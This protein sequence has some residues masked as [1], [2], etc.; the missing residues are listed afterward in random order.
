[1]P[2]VSPAAN[3]ETICEE[4]F[5]DP[6]PFLQ[7]FAPFTYHFPMD[8]LIAAMKYQ[9]RPQLSKLLAKLMI[10]SLA[11]SQQQ[12]PELFIPIPMHPS[13]QRLR[14]YNQAH[15]LAK[16]LAN[17]LNTP[18][19]DQILVKSQH[20]D[21]QKGLSAK[22]RQANLA[23]AFSVNVKALQKLPSVTHVVLVDDVITTGATMKA[24]A[25]CLHDAG[26]ERID[27][28]AVARTP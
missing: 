12:A 18:L 5:A 16:H 9:N 27:I 7:C 15:Y 11:K 13:R 19:A 1:M 4:C 17:Y 25:Q 3:L 21:S 28:W 6:P 10:K 14:G 24:A 26:I 2:L 23:S 22:D 20:T 8:Q